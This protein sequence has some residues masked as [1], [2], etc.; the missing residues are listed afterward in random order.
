MHVTIKKRTDWSC[1]VDDARL[2]VGKDGSAR[3]PSLEFKRQILVAEHSPIRNLLFDITWFDIPYWVANQIRTHHVGFHSGEDDLIFIKTSR[4]DRTQ[5]ERDNLPQN[6]PVNMRAVINAHSLINVSRVRLCCLAS[7]E[8]REAWGAMVFELNSIE[9]LL[10]SLCVPNCIFKGGLCPET[11]NC[12]GYNKTKEF[13][14]SLE[15]YKNLYVC[16]L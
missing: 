5:K 4:S 13:R 2:T 8:T 1:V 3:D 12:C 15:S 16:N 6:A 10:V 14:N 7:P 9:P 11:A